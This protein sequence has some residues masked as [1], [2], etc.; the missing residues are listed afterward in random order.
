MKAYQLMMFMLLFCLSISVIDVLNIYQFNEVNV[1]SEYNTERTGVTEPSRTTDRF[2]GSL[3]ASAAIGAIAGA[4]V[5]YLTKVPADSAF[6]Y[7][8]FATS[9]WGIAYNALATIWELAPNNQGIGVII[10]IFSIV[11]AG[12]FAVGMAQLIRGGWKSYV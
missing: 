1:G 10:V 8:I 9:F 12:T 2:F 5:S 7:S 3:L 6:A 4:V 11:L